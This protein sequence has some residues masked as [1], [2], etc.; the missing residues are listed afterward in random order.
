MFKS[1]KACNK[2]VTV[3]NILVIKAR[4]TTKIRCFRNKE[5]I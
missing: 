2:I 4:N 3:G 5:G 1:Q